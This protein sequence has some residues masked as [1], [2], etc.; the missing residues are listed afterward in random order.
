MNDLMT[1]GEAARKVGASTSSL[2]R[3]ASDPALPA[4]V[5]VQRTTG[6]HLRWSE[7]SVMALKSALAAGWQPSGTHETAEL[8]APLAQGNAA[9]RHVGFIVAQHLAALSAI[10]LFAECLYRI[11]VWKQRADWNAFAHHTARADAAA[12]IDSLGSGRNMVALG[13][14]LLIVVASFWTFWSI[15]Q[16]GLHTALGMV[17]IAATLVIILALS[18]ATPKFSSRQQSL[19]AQTNQLLVRAYTRG[20]FTLKAGSKLYLGDERSGWDGISCSS[21]EDSRC[22][23]QTLTRRDIYDLASVYHLIGQRCQTLSQNNFGRNGIGG[24]GTDEPILA[25]FSQNGGPKSLPY[26]YELRMRMCLIGE[27]IR[28][29]HGKLKP[30]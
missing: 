18:L 12:L 6:G 11:F 2:R 19:K 14:L 20:S 16:G 27:Q 24:S 21:G 8:P 22:I 28:I 25:R 29:D 13:A 1:T 23:A 15:D 3:W 17:S 10:A 7:Q 4:G 26:G 9:S 30:R 5:T